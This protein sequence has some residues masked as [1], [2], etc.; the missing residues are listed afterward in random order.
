MINLGYILLNKNATSGKIESELVIRYK[1]LEFEVNLIEYLH[2]LRDK[3]P[4]LFAR[5]RQFGDQNVIP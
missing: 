4:E 2:I 5:N 3:I 1:E